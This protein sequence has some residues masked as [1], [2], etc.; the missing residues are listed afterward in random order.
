MNYKKVFRLQTGK[1]VQV[2]LEDEP[3]N[4]ID[5]DWKVEAI[6]LGPQNNLQGEY[7]FRGS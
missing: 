3:Q 7:L 2:N 4:I 1:Y 5:I 6:F